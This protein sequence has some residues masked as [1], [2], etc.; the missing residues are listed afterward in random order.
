VNNNSGSNCC[1]FDGGNGDVVD[2]HIYVGPGT[3]HQPS[4]ARV[5]VLGE[6]GGL[7]LTSP[8][9]QWPGTGFAYEMTSDATALTDRYVSI[10]EQL[11]P[12]ILNNGLSASIYTQPAD[13]ENEINGLWT[14]DRRVLK[15]NADRVRTVNRSVIQSATGLATGSLVSL[16]VTTSGFTDRFLRH[17]NGLARTDVVNAAGADGLKLDATFW[18]RQGLANNTCYSFESRN[19]AGHYLRHADFRVRKDARDGTALFDQDATFCAQPP[20]AGT[21]GVSLAS[22]NISGHHIRHY[23]EAVYIAV[24]GGSHAFDASAGYDQDVTWAVAPPWAP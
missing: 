11:K 5:A 14:Y 7:G 16:R 6:F 4:S 24:P 3:P 21:T 2:D 9:H 13:V 10:N 12:L 20:R 18:V 19:F 8:G 1:G 15:M 23:A 17:Q 22:Y